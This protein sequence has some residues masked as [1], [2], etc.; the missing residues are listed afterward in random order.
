MPTIPSQVCVSAKYTV[1]ILTPRDAALVCTRHRQGPAP[2][3]PFL[4][5][6]SSLLAPRFSFLLLEPSAVLPASC[7]LLIASQD[8]THIS[9]MF[10]SSSTPVRPHC[11]ARVP[12]YPPILARARR[13]RDAGGNM[14]Q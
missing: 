14:M 4:A 1:P 7:A 12:G 11:A 3:T 5:P 8:H 9:L 6:R 10:A 13:R 2:R